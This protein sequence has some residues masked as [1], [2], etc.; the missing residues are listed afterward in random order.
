MKRTSPKSIPSQVTRFKRGVASA[1]YKEDLYNFVEYVG[2]NN[3]AISRGFT[4][5]KEMRAHNFREADNFFKE[6]TK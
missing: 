1:P 3:L 5:V 4:S 6:L 2:M